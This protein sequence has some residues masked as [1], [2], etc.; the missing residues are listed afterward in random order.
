[1][2]K[3]KE[4]FL[5]HWRHK[6]PFQEIFSLTGTVY[7]QIADRKTLQFNFAEGSYFI[8][9]HRGT[10]LGEI[11]KN[12]LTLRLPVVDASNEWRAIERLQANGVTTMKGVAFG[13]KGFNPLTRL[14]F[15]ITEDLS[16]AL[17]LEELTADWAQQRPD[18]ALKLKLINTLA[19]TVRKMH[20]CGVNHR[21]CYLCHFL[22]KQDK[23][24]PAEPCSLFIIDLHR[25]QTR[26]KVP[27]RWRDK[28]LI[29]LYFSSLNIGLTKRDILRFLQIYFDQPLSEILGQQRPL[30][31]I[32]VRKAEKIRRRTLLKGL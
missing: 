28:D 30:L 11:V 32:A 23:P 21:D 12:L 18:R 1:M 8:K 22:V 25:A 7:R 26:N 29:G 20:Q 9:I 15:I 14:S 3:L 4:P 6:D 10:T 5:S 17:S 2:I 19:T 16:P 24:L 27:Q 31:A 13:S